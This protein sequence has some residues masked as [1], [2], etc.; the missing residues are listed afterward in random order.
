M[1]ITLYV[2]EFSKPYT[3]VGI[4]SHFGVEITR[5][6]RIIVLYIYKVN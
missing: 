4:F 3:P 1:I 2:T 5:T 6:N